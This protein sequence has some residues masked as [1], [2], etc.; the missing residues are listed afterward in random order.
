VFLKEVDK[1]ISDG[2]DMKIISHIEE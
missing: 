1:G 2:V